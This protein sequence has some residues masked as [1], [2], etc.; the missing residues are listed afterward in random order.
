LPEKT[1]RELVGFSAG[2]SEEQ[3]PELAKLKKGVAAVYQNDWVEPVLVQIRKCAIEEKQYDFK[4]HSMLVGTTAYRNQLV[5]LLIQGRLDE[6]LE[7]NVD[8]I[9]SGLERLGLSIRNEKF[10]V[11]ILNEYREKNE[12]SIWKNEQFSKL[13]SVVSEILGVRKR[14]E[15]CVL[16]VSNNDELSQDLRRIVYQFMP[17]A[18]DEVILTLSQCFMKDMSVQQKETEIKKQLYE[19]WFDSAKEGGILL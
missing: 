7:F 18:S 4:A 5:N 13:S 6:K 2:L 9:E 10:V 3:I 11:D 15:N 16:S 19:E 1:D 8:E 12:L 17:N 14:V